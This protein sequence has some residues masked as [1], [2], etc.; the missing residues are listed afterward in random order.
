[1]VVKVGTIDRNERR[2]LARLI[3]DYMKICKDIENTSNPH[4]L[5][6]LNY[7]RVDYHRDIIF[8]MS[9]DDGDIGHSRNGWLANVLSNMDKYMG[10]NDF[11]P[12]YEQWNNHLCKN[13]AYMLLA[14]KYFQGSYPDIRPIKESV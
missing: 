10:Y 2:I 7:A 6:N 14:C 5:E 4:K 3:Y 13:I 11:N 8:F 1:M 9:I 12:E